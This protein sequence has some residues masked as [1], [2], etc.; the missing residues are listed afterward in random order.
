MLPKKALVAAGGD[1][2]SFCESFLCSPIF[3]DSSRVCG[4]DRV[5]RTSLGMEG[6]SLEKCKENVCKCIFNYL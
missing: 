4:L 1:R 3:D 6:I 2:T 5:N